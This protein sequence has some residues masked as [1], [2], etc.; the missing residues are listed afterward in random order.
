M[1]DEQPITDSEGATVPSVLNPYIGFRDN[2]RQAMEFYK[3]VF[4]GELKLNTFG[5]YAIRMRPGQ[6]TSC[7]D[8]L[9]PIKASR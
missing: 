7:M 3:D 5:E 2:A 6:T 8:S 1:C 9:K 4:G